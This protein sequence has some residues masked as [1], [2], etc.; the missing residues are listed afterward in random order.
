MRMGGQWNWLMFVCGVESSCPATR[1]LVVGRLNFSE[2]GCEDGEDDRT[3]SGL[4]AVLRVVLDF[5]L[6]LCSECC[7]LSSG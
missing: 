1:E 2:V 3:G 5:K 7:M 4:C 6:S